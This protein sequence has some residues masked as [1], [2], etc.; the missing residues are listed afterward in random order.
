MPREYEPKAIELAVN[1][2]KALAMDAVEKAQSGHPG[3]PMGLSD[4]TFEIFTR[5][6]RYDPRDPAWIG[7]D[8]FVLSC[9]HASSGAILARWLTRL[10]KW[11]KARPAVG[12][13]ILPNWPRR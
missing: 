3:T 5:Y 10:T 2:I 8:R 13:W 4:I 7:R 12:G 11:K 6:L 9:G 1:T